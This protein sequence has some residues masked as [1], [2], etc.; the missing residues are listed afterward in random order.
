MCKYKDDIYKVSS[1]GPM[2]FA[3]G[4]PTMAPLDLYQ[5]LDRKDADPEGHILM[6]ILNTAVVF[7]EFLMEEEVSCRIRTPCKTKL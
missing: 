3:E 5:Y 2:V 1:V 7:M 6:S 4:V